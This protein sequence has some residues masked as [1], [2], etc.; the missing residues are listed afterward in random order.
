M[1]ANL[2]WMLAAAGLAAP[3]LVL[4][5]D[6]RPVLDS[7]PGAE[8]HL[9]ACDQAS[10]PERDCL[11]IRRYFIDAYGKALKGDRSSQASVAMLL[12]VGARVPGKPQS[13]VA[14]D[15]V[16]ACAWRIVAAGDQPD[17]NGALAIRY[18]CDRLGE[19]DRA[20]AEAR[21]D[22]LRQEIGV[23]VAAARQASTEAANA[24]EVRR[25]QEGRAGSATP[26]WREQEPPP[27]I[28]LDAQKAGAVIATAAHCGAEPIRLARVSET[29]EAA[30][31]LL[32]QTGTLRIEAVRV[33]RAAR[34]AE[35]A[36]LRVTRSADCPEVLSILRRTER[37]FGI[38]DQVA[39]ER[40]PPS[41]ERSVPNAT[42]R[43]ALEAGGIEAS[44]EKCGI[45]S[46][47]IARITDHSLTAIERQAVDDRERIEV[48]DLYKAGRE[49]RRW[50]L[51]TGLVDTPVDCDRVR[52]AIAELERKWR[53]Q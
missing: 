19:A 22:R 51:R 29:T 24:A 47:R 3:A 25:S 1:K 15:P 5:Q 50:G 11:S 31:L 2:K 37:K 39:F 36:R 26:Q 43:A 33:F 21:A 16:E 8:R 32:G 35:E 9:V 42:Q 6:A 12:T 41:I 48:F 44:A 4:A 13:Y 52:T 23:Q 28:I 45:A 10:G 30:L 38:A 7:L 14:P 53:L 49:T 27:T 18:A 46:T 20:A 40:L 17:R 34:E